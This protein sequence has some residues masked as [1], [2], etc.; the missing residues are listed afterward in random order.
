MNPGG[1]NKLKVTIQGVS[2]EVIV[3][4]SEEKEFFVG[5]WEHVQPGYLMIELQ[6]V[7]RTAEYFG[8]VTSFGISGTAINSTTAYVKDNMDNYFYWGRRGPSVHL[9]YTLPSSD[10]TDFYSELTFPN[11]EAGVT[12]QFLLHGQPQSDNSTIYTAYFFAPEENNWML[13]ASFKRPIPILKIV[14]SS[15]QIQSLIVNSILT[16]L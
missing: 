1:K 12:Y 7:S 4:G 11:G 2:K 10:I 14:D 15:F 5:R 8:T 9:K 13:I 3:E 16:S 6:G